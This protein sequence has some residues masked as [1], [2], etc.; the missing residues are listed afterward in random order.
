MFSS[1]QILTSFQ[2]HAIFPHAFSMVSYTQHKI[3]KSVSTTTASRL[4]FG[5]ERCDPPHR[6]PPENSS[7]RPRN[8]GLMVS[9]WDFSRGTTTSENGIDW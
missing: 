1:F 8:D 5:A 3:R 6:Y 7:V 4:H 9:S 2:F